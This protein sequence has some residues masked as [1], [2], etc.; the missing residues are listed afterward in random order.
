MLTGNSLTAPNRYNE[1]GPFFFLY[2][3]TNYRQIRYTW[4]EEK[5]GWGELIFTIF[6]FFLFDRKNN[7]PTIFLFFLSEIETM[8]EKIL[9]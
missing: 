1:G 6:L 5:V 3:F 8:I 4:R 9:F 2:I 7:Y